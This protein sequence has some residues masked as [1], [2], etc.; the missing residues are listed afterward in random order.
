[1]SWLEF[2]WT[3]PH[4]CVNLCMEEAAANQLIPLDPAR[5]VN[6]C[7]RYCDSGEIRLWIHHH[8]PENCTVSKDC[9]TGDFL[10]GLWAWLLWTSHTS[11]SATISPCGLQRL[12]EWEYYKQQTHRKSMHVTWL[13]ENHCGDSSWNDAKQSVVL[14]SWILS[15]IY[16]DRISVMHMNDIARNQM[17]WKFSGKWRGEAI[18]GGWIRNVQRKCIHSQSLRC[19]LACWNIHASKIPSSTTIEY[20]PRTS[21]NPDFGPLYDTSMTLPVHWQCWVSS[22]CRHRA[23]FFISLMHAKSVPQ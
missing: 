1:M 3:W 19:L 17:R 20:L 15:Q 7:F 9:P 16:R 14:D 4:P 21:L 22:R 2:F 23:V 13:C 18:K 5:S 11:V 6:R 8:N 12:S 10:A